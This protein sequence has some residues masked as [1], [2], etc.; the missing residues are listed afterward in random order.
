MW[1]DLLSGQRH[2]SEAR[3]GQVGREQIGPRHQRS[4]RRNELQL[5]ALRSTKTHPLGVRAGKASA[6]RCVDDKATG[7]TARHAHSKGARAGLPRQTR[8]SHAARKMAWVESTCWQQRSRSPI[9]QLGSRHGPIGEL[10]S[11]HSGVRK[12]GT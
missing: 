12:V 4:Q 9:V 3:P 5:P 7:T 10:D 6:D 8:T 1:A 11:V 2:H